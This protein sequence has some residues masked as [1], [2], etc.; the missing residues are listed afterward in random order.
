[1]NDMEKAILDLI[2][3]HYHK[4]KKITNVFIDI[5]DEYILEYGNYTIDNNNYIYGESV[6]EC[7]NGLQMILKD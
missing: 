5:V 1:M 3:K 6:K 4:I 2:E 7:F